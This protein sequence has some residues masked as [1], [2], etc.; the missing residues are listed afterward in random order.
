[1]SHFAHIDANNIVTKVI[2][3][4][5]SFIDSGA[6]GPASEWIECSITH[7]FR[8]R[9]PGIGHM[10]DSTRDEFM[11]PKPEQYPSWIWNEQPGPNGAWVA[12]IPFPGTAVNK[13]LFD[14]DEATTSWIEKQPADILIELSGKMT[15]ALYTNQ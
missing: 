9:Y 5:Q 8:G 14:W 3:A 4:D 11:P 7:S 6:V 15:Q 2:A 13:Q 10:Y 12:P 1:M